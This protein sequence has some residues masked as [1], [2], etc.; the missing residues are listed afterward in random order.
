[1]IGVGINALGI[2][3]G[4]IVGLTRKKTLTAANESFFKV[5]MGAAAVFLGLQ[6]TWR[7]LNGSVGVFFKQLL[8][9]LVS[10]SLGKLIGKLFHLQKISNS[11]GK[12]ATAK[13]AVANSTQKSFS[14]GLVVAALLSCANPLGIFASVQEGLTGFS[15]LFVVKAVMDGL[16]AMAFVSIFGWGVML[17]A[18]P[19][20]AFQG[21]I[22]LLAKSLEP[23]LKSHGLADSILATDGLLIFC[24]ALIILNLKKVELA[25]YIPSLAIAPLITWLWK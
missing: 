8:I 6:L 18:I 2:V 17:A 3:V 13:M 24:V 20:V 25:D 15:A 21:T 5:A 4:G 7:N 22:F 14:E 12:Y 10:M 16:A 23:F 9:V 11:I 1:M 19:V